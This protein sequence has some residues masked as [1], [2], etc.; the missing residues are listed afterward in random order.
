MRCGFPLL[1]GGENCGAVKL[2]ARLFGASA[3]WRTAAVVVLGVLMAQGPLGLAA[4]GA[5]RWVRLARSPP[6]AIRRV[7]RVLRAAWC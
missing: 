5:W 3:P 2:P 7:F 6:G 4:G 1:G